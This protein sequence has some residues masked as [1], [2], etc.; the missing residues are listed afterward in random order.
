MPRLLRRIDTREVS[1]VDRPASRRRFAIVKQDTTPEEGRAMSVRED[2]LEGIGAIR[3]A[4]SVGEI[5]EAMSALDTLEGLLETALSPEDEEA[6]AAR[7]P[8]EDE[9]E[10]GKPRRKPATPAMARIEK[11]AASLIE[12][13][14]GA[15]RPLTR[16]QAIAQVVKQNPGLYAAYDREREAALRR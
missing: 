2:V 6:K 16:E 9:D 3:E 13:S 14:A 15:D 7:R 1:L 5:D 12:K 4:L 11:M 10:D 8:P